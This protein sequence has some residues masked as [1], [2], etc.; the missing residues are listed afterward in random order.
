[1]SQISSNL[2]LVSPAAT[3]WHLGPIYRRRHH[4]QL[5]DSDTPCLRK[6][7]ILYLLVADM[8]FSGGTV[9][10]PMSDEMR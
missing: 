5:S 8:K 2:T 1:M 10:R 6:M 3:N 7:Q 9:Y 4:D